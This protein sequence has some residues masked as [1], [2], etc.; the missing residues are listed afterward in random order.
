VWTHRV[1]GKHNEFMAELISATS[2]CSFENL[3]GYGVMRWR[4]LSAAVTSESGPYVCIF[5]GVYCC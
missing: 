1:F 3:R 2:G 5:I 4:G